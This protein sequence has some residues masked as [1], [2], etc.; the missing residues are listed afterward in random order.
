MGFTLPKLAHFAGGIWHEQ[1]G[2]I[3]LT[4][5][6]IFL[7]IANFFNCRRHFVVSSILKGTEMKKA[8]AVGIIKSSLTL[9][10]RLLG[11]FYWVSDTSARLCPGYPCFQRF[12]CFDLELSSFV[13]CPLGTSPSRRWSKLKSTIS[14]NI[15]KVRILKIALKANHLFCN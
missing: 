15:K 14:C 10:Q 9:F 1:D 13:R 11:M 7:S 2:V 4:S 3:H 6:L 12:G 5:K 8:N